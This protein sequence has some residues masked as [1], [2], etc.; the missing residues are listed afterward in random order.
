MA[1]VMSSSENRSVTKTI[2]QYKN[3]YHP[4]RHWWPVFVIVC[5]LT[6]ATRFYKVA[7]PDH[8]W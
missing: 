1:Q 4:F 3:L 7:E 5:A 2:L 8:V 6:L